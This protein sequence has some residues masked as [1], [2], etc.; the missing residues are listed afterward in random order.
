MP[1]TC[2]ECAV[3]IAAAMESMPSPI[4]AEMLRRTRILGNAARDILRE[5]SLYNDLPPRLDA[6]IRSLGT[7]L[8]EVNTFRKVTPAECVVSIYLKLACDNRS[9]E[10]RTSQMSLHFDKRE[11]K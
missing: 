2:S 5:A 7:A 9:T 1:P 11:S 10:R 3:K 8:T 6:A 4:L